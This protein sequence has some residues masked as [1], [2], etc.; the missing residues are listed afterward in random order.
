M[1]VL[2]AVA[3]FPMRLH[4]PYAFIGIIVAVVIVYLILR[5]AGLI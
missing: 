5:L 4:G 2:P 3:S 1:P